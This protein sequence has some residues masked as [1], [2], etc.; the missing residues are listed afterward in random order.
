MKEHTRRCLGVA[1]F[2]CVSCKTPSSAP[3]LPA[4]SA[5]AQQSLASPPGIDV[6]AMDESVNACDDF[7]KYACGGWL[8]TA[9]I[10][11]DRDSWSRGFM[12]IREANKAKLR[13]ILDAVS[14]GQPPAPTPYAQ[15]L[16]AFYAGCM[17][18][19]QLE[20]ALP[21][22]HRE[23]DGFLKFQPQSPLMF[24][25]A[26]AKLHSRGVGA[27][28]ERG[29]TQDA[30][31]ASEVIGE[32][33]QGGLG[34]P[35]RDFYLSEK[36]EKTKVLDAYRAHV[37]AVF[38]LF[39]EKPSRAKDDMETVLRLETQLAQASDTKVNRRDPHNTYHR[40]DR[41]A[42]KAAAP[43]FAWDAYFE[44]MGTKDLGAINVTYPPFFKQ[45]AKMTKAVPA[46]DW[47][48]YLTY[49]YLRSRTLALPMA[50]QEEQFQFT[51]K[52]LTGAKEDKP[53]W[54][55]C[56]ELSDEL[57]GES[58]GVPFVE[59]TF[60]E[61]GKAKSLEVVKDIEAAFEANLGSL[62]WMDDATRAQALSKLKMVSN[63]IGYPDSWRK[64]DGLKTN[65]KDFLTSLGD[66]MAFE[67]ARVLR[68][69]GRPLNRQEWLMSTP[70]VNA[71]YQPP[72]NEVVFPAGIL[73]PPFF[74]RE[75]TFPVNF[76]AMGMV[77]GHEFTHGFDDEGSQ[78]DGTGNMRDWWSAASAAAFK[79]RTQCVK[80]QFDGYVA[81]DDLHVNGAL[82]LGENVA[83]LGG[84][85]FAHAAMRAWVKSHPNDV[86]SYRFSP[87]QQF[88]LGFAQAWCGVDRP[89]RRKL[90]TVTDPHSP[91]NLR[92][93]GP[94]SNLEAFQQAFSCPA[95]SKMVRP[96]AEQCRVW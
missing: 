58:L 55:K 89:E 81:I 40:M 43:E 79:E 90:L 96:A 28:F 24:A 35:D 75:A 77:V 83:D 76:G 2:L 50:F 25:A 15:E 56:V 16:G 91:P 59:T 73:Q 92:V 23:L 11:P 39:G 19:T 82:T 84:L 87:D 61:D 30:R 64:Y 34:L 47:K 80:K 62:A 3:L 44:A 12:T 53:R 60:G 67:D 14:Q 74:S 41:S 49:H 5:A 71:Y 94:L 88:F 54:K 37:A 70:T 7:Y 93:D 27:V 42:L 46:K 36:P 86:A 52:A 45:M 8:K 85:R 17:D 21:A 69:I 31:D 78:Y 48:A 57:M 20:G 29:S 63:K 66:A 38:R 26:L 68:K 51:S 72:M 1:L 65:R 32:V 22:A 6:S 95:G 33:D 18:E 13:A 10:P 4:P 9:Q